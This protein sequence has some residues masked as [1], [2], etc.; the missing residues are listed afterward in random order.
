VF[1]LSLNQADLKRIQ[2]KLDK[3]KQVNTPTSKVYQYKL[4]VLTD[5]A[6]AIQSVMGEV[7][8]EGG[9]MNS[10]L[11]MGKSFQVSW[12][13]LSDATV[14]LKRAKGWELEIWEAT[15]TTKSAVRV[16]GDFA[17]I[18]GTTHKAAYDHA[19][20]AEFGDFNV[21]GTQR[22]TKRALFTVANDLIMRN[23]ELIL[24]E[25]G[26]RVVSDMEWGTK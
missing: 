7:H 16:A 20:T 23:K 2:G 14:E 17:G 18:D 15:G 8:H 9:S 12:E 6:Q 21:V 13:A 25:I 10:D 24:K 3:L 26:K 4:K 19:L 5:Y 1:K 11:V 22:S